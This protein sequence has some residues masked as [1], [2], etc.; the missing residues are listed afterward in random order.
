MQQR[1]FPESRQLGRGLFK[2]RRAGNGGEF[3]ELWRPPVVADEI[4]RVPD[5]GGILSGKSE[6]DVGLAV[7][8]IISRRKQVFYRGGVFARSSQMKISIAPKSLSS[9][10]SPARYAPSRR[11][12]L[13]SGGISD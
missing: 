6:Q 9:A 4:Y 10:G 5:G 1:L 13:S 8:C 3:R 12:P 7:L 11:Y 2:V